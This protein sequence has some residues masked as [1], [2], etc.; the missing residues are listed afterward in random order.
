MD[1]KSTFV[2][3]DNRLMDIN[4]GMDSVYLVGKFQGRAVKVKDPQEM[5]DVLKHLIEH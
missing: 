3:N 1:L 5:E 4:D 2:I